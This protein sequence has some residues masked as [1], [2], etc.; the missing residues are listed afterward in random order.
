MANHI[1]FDIETRKTT[2]ADRLMPEF[3]PPKLTQKGEPYANSKTIAEQKEAWESDCALSPMTGEICMLTCDD[4]T[5]SSLTHAEIGMLG[6]F[7]RLYEKE[8]AKGSYFVSYG[9]FD[10]DFIITRSR[11]L[12][13]QMPCT[14]NP[15]ERYI[16]MYINLAEVLRCYDNSQ[17]KKY[18]SLEDWAKAFGLPELQYK[19]YDGKDVGAN[20][21]WFLDNHPDIAI[22]HNQEDVQV[23]G[24]LIKRVLTK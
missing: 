3:K 4:L 2:M 18:I 15:L 16:P 12:G 6:L 21:G 19:V 23:L 5:L 1:P 8:T 9:R 17:D 20:F 11:I 10:I 24:E 7:W 14:I 13:V 22:K